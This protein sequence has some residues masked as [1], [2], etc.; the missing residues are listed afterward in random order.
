[1]ANERPQP[2]DFFMIVCGPVPLRERMARPDA[3]IA[4]ATGDAAMRQNGW[5]VL[6]VP[7]TS[8]PNGA[9][10]GAMEP[11]QEPSPGRGG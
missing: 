5:K 3:A 4:I 2:Y 8:D 1:M 7:L 6:D 9:V 11:E 10:P